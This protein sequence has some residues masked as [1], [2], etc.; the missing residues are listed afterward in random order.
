ME[1]VFNEL[2]PIKSAT[3]DLNKKMVVFADQIIQGKLI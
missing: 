3:I 2:G 1:L